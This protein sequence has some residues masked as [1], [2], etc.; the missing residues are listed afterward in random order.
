MANTYTLISAQT[1]ASSAASVTFS[2]IPATYT[3]LVVKISCRSDRTT[4]GSAIGFY[5]NAS[6]TASSWTYLYGNGS[7]A[8]SSLG[9]ASYSPIGNV[10]GASQTANSFNS[11]EIYIPNYAGAAV[12]PFSTFGVNEYN[13]ASTAPIYMA[14]YAGLYNAT[15]AISNFTLQ[16]D[17]GFNFVTGSSFY[18]YGIKN[19]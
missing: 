16:P 10:N 9:T 11:A 3:D 8:G 5:P 2:S 15:T 13:S 7:A 1:L 18:L 14:A 17:G 6:S 4:Y 19:S 12:K